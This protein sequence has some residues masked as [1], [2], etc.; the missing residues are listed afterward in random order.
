MRLKLSHLAALGLAVVFATAVWQRPAFAQTDEIQVYD[1]SLAAPGVINLT[2]HNNYTPDG[3]KTPAFPGAIVSNHS[4]N[5]VTEWAYGVTDWFE[6]GLYFPLYSHDMNHGLTYNGFKLR[7]LFAVPH[8]ED[9]VFFYG[10]NFEFSF[11]KKHWDQKTHTLEVRPIIGWHL[12]KVDLVFNPI[13]DSS[14]NGIKKW[15]FDPETR[16]AYNIDK[17]WAVAAEEYDGFGPL[18]G[19]NAANQQTHELFGVVDYSGSPLEVEA[20]VGFG[21]TR[22][23]DNVTFKLILAADL[24]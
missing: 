1:G 19:F 4:W 9:R 14:Y 18:N 15:E 13:L 16:I 20:G 6:A 23:S 17:T 3:V 21:L 24:N 11:N 7:T 2:W 12:G 22:A 5:G 10:V 8:A